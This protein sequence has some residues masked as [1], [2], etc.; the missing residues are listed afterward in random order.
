VKEADL[1]SV[2]MENPEFK[3]GKLKIELED[4]EI[5][6]VSTNAGLDL[7]YGRLF[8]TAKTELDRP[9]ASIDVSIRLLVFG[10]FWIEALCNETLRETLSAAVELPKLSEALWEAAKRCS[11]LDKLP[12]LIALERNP[13]A[14][15]AETLPQI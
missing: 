7:A 10:C 13:N 15:R 1:A 4:G 5:I 9:D 8:Q 14:I 11:V 2:L 3:Y 12:I 6:G